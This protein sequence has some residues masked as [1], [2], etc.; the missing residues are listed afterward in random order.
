ML[1]PEIDRPLVVTNLSEWIMKCKNSGDA[2]S[3]I[4]IRE[5]VNV[6]FSFGEARKNKRLAKQA[7]RQIQVNAQLRQEAENLE[8]YGKQI[9][10]GQI[11]STFVELYEKGYVRIARFKGL[12]LVGDFEKLVSIDGSDGN[13]QKKSAAGRAAG[14]VLTGGLNMLSS[15]IRGDLILTVVTGTKVH[16]ISTQVGS[17]TELE[18][19]HRLKTSGKALLSGLEAAKSSI[20]NESTILSLS[21]ELEKLVKLRDSGALSD[22]EFQRAKEKLLPGEPK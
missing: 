2:L 22:D 14:A 16:S 12:K 17:S 6:T 8:K 18:A 3:A 7:K 4:E 10:R 1:I 9:D 21:G 5:R 11:E 13:V 20:S 15:N 19:I